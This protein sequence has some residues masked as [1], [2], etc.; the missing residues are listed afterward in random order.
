MAL[1]LPS[2][3]AIARAVAYRL[4]S[5]EVGMID[6]H[7][8]LTLRYAA[9]DAATGVQQQVLRVALPAEGAMRAAMGLLEVARE[10][11]FEEPDAALSP[12]HEKSVLN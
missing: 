10:L 9:A 5:Y 11:A 3:N 1:A 12:K 7:V 2:D 8:V 4:L 6:D